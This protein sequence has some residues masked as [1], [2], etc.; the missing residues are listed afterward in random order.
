MRQRDLSSSIGS[1]PWRGWS[2]NAVMSIMRGNAILM[3]QQLQLYTCA[4][5]QFQQNHCM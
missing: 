2:E 5:L 1:T 3:S 4:G